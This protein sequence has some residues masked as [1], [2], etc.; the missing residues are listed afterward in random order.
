MGT[1]GINQ[2]ERSEE[3]Q[4][5]D[6]ARLELEAVKPL[7]PE[8]NSIIIEDWFAKVEWPGK[9][10]ATLLLHLLKSESPRYREI[11]ERILDRLNKDIEETEGMTAQEDMYVREL[12]FA[13]SGRPGA[14]G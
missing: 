6:P 11:G 13:V 7:S 4:R 5:T 14:K 2:T 1:T 8:R 3:K 9:L 10:A 12:L